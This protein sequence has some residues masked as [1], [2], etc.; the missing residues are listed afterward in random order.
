MTVVAF[1]TL[2]F[3]KRLEDAGVPAVQAA[4]TASAFTEATGDVIATKIDVDDLR[5]DLAALRAEFKTDIAS[6]RQE[7]KGDLTSV[8]QELKA[9]IVSV[10]QDMKTLELRMTIKL[11]TM[12]VGAA[13]LHATLT[14]L[15]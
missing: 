4:A 8:R 14:K 5:R 10:R 13:A 7:L 11:G 9:D 6:L 3:A 1:D 12:L 15:L 2:R